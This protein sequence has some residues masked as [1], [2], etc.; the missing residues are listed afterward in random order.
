MPIPQFG[1]WDQ[2]GP[3]GTDYSMVFSRAR[4]NKKQQK[5]DIKRYSIGNEHELIPPPP[6][7]QDDPI[8]GGLLYFLLEF[9]GIL[10]CHHTYLEMINIFG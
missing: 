9:N 5:A 7:P 10:A 2:K 1:G 8:M 3:G 6:Q 4:A